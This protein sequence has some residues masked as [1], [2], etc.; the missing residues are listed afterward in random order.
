M[1]PFNILISCL[2]ARG[3]LV[4]FPCA[5]CFGPSTPWF[6]SGDEGLRDL[7]DQTSL[8]LSFQPSYPACFSTALEDLAGI[9]L[10]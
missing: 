4:E 8:S 5:R 9:H 3:A 2:Q 10:A 1:Y 7:G 6:P